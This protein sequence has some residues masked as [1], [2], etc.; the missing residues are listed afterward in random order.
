L[1]VPHESG[2][3]GLITLK[4]PEIAIRCLYLRISGFHSRRGRIKRTIPLYLEIFSHRRCSFV[5]S[6]LDNV[7]YPD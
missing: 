2:I 1:L 5:P 6:H 7:Y 3:S 4:D